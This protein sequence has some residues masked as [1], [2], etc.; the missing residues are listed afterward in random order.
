MSRSRRRPKQDNESTYKLYTSSELDN[1]LGFDEADK[2]IDD[3]LLRGCTV[4]ELFARFGL[5][6][7]EETETNT[8]AKTRK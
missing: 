3:M 4:S 5:V 1:L 6:L 8:K 7:D 2:V